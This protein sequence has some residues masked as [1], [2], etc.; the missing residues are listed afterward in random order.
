MNMGTDIPKLT[1]SVLFPFKKG[2]TTVEHRF[3]ECN[4]CMPEHCVMPLTTHTSHA[5][6]IQ[7]KPI[8]YAEFRETSFRVAM[9]E[10]KK[11]PLQFRLMYL[12]PVGGS[13]KCGLSGWSVSFALIGALHAMTPMCMSERW[14]AWRIM[15]VTMTKRQGERCHRIMLLW[16]NNRKKCQDFPH[17]TESALDLLMDSDGVSVRAD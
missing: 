11:W 17:N 8:V 16:R 15:T 9:T 13:V 4:L 10:G 5:V 3:Q 1:R 12:R 14:A 6:H 2:K 7:K